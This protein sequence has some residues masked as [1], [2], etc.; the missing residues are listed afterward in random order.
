[1]RLARLLNS[2]DVE[3]APITLSAARAIGA[4][5][6]ACGHPDIV[7]VHVALCARERNHAVVTSDPTD[8]GR[9]DATLALIRV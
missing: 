8:L 7:D 2:S 5:G 6:A 4:L 1:V 3:V 9:V